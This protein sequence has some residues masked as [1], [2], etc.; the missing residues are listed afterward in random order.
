MYWPITLSRRSLLAACPVLVGGSLA[1]C[2]MTQDERANEGSGTGATSIIIHNETNTSQ[3][4]SVTATDSDGKTWIDVTDT[5]D[6][7]KHVD[8]L[9]LEN[10]KR[11]DQRVSQLPVGNDYTI[12]VAVD[13]GVS[14]TLEWED[15][16]LDL[17]PLRLLVIDKSYI[18]FTLQATP[19][20]PEKQ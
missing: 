1:G 14:Q 3:S 15:V 5:I 13:G 7:H 9:S 4:V 16:T 8:P 17:A 12:D 18:A 19:V 10:A 20:R 2:T 11:T 6:A